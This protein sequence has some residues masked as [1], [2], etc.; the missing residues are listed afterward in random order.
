MRARR[1][2]GGR[3]IHPSS[4]FCERLNWSSSNPIDDVEKVLRQ[5]QV[6]HGRRVVRVDER[7]EEA[8]LCEARREIEYSKLARVL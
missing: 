5:L 2:G 1:G 6:T 4:L 3:R 7:H 8:T